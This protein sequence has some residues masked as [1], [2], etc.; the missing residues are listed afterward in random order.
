MARTYGAHVHDKGNTC[1][2]RKGVCG[3]VKPEGRCNSYVSSHL[4]R[5]WED[6]EGG[7]WIRSALT[8][9]VSTFWLATQCYVWPCVAMC[10]CVWL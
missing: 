9:E 3:K 6:W 10:G 7:G 2:A 4:D 5:F 8:G 1:M